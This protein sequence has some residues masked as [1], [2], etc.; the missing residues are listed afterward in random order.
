MW[1]MSLGATLQNLVHLPILSAPVWAVGRLVGPSASALTSRGWTLTNLPLTML[2]NA[3]VRVYYPLVREVRGREDRLGDALQ[4][5]L[6]VVS[7]LVA[8]A[9]GAVSGLADE[10]VYVLLGSKWDA[11]ADLLP[12]FA[13]LACVYSLNWASWSFA[14]ADHRSRQIWMAQ[15][16]LIGT[17]L[18]SLGVQSLFGVTSKG[19]IAAVLL[20]QG[21]SH[22]VHLRGYRDSLRLGRLIRGYIGH[23]G[24]GCFAFLV[25][26]AVS[27]TPLSPIGTLMLG[28]VVLPLSL[29]L[30]ALY[31]KRLIPGLGL[32]IN[33]ARDV[34]M[35]KRGDARVGTEEGLVHDA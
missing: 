15:G 10:V 7:L 6:L 18:A 24:V 19:I 1:R 28:A 27:D 11:V 12:A 3:V 13:L 8:T 4:K 23:A 14:E 22:L 34:R 30:L 32:L 17:A 31:T 20:G 16:A 33:A 26:K 5:L 2:M 9:M 29:G 35:G 21:A 25:A